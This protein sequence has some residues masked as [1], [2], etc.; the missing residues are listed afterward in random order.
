MEAHSDRNPDAECLL[1]VVLQ[2]PI[3]C[4]QTIFEVDRPDKVMRALD[5]GRKI[6]FRLMGHLYL[7]CRHRTSAH[8]LKKWFLRGATAERSQSMLLARNSTTCAS[9][10]QLVYPF[11]EKSAVSMRSLLDV[12]M[13]PWGPRC[14]DGW[15]GFGLGQQRMRGVYDRVRQERASLQEEMTP[16]QACEFGGGLDLF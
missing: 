3:K 15:A 11:F 16:V 4:N 7:F 14:E 12:L 1:D 9:L 8:S 10:I 2:C 5:Q 13:M 6:G